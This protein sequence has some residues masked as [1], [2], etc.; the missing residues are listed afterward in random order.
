MHAD[1]FFRRVFSPIARCTRA[2]A[3]LA[4]TLATNER[5]IHRTR[6]RI[7]RL[8]RVGVGGQRLQ[9]GPSSHLKNLLEVARARFFFTW[10]PPCEAAA[11][12]RWS[13]WSC[14]CWWWWWCCCWTA[15][16][17]GSALH[18][19]SS[20]WWSNREENNI[21]KTRKCVLSGLKSWIENKIQT[22]F[23]FI[24]LSS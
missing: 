16:S 9:S 5:V 19:M 18:P 12:C 3:Q 15:L 6:G 8:G 23:K 21:E 22:H 13:C 17:T 11:R 2:R 20:D 24:G 4:C 7:G 14:W 1:I 10:P